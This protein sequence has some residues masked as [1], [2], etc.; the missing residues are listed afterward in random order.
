M[1]MSDN[2]GVEIIYD[3]DDNPIDV[4]VDNDPPPLQAPLRTKKFPGPKTITREDFGEVRYDIFVAMYANGILD[5]EHGGQGPFW[6]NLYNELFL[7]GW[8]DDIPP[9]L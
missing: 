9:M 2:S 7:G 1:N 4:H 6:D 5:L 3:D 8:S